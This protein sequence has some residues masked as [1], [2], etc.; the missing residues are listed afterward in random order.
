MS[1]TVGTAD[2]TSRVEL[3]ARPP[4]GARAI[5]KGEAVMGIGG[6]CE[7]GTLPTVSALLDSTQA[8]QAAAVQDCVSADGT[9]PSLSAYFFISGPTH[10]R[11]L[12]DS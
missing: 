10:L 1:K 12:A 4:R 2:E 5:E 8:I 7:R 6:R 3:G 11:A 9:P